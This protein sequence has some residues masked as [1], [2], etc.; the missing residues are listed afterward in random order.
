MSA[1]LGHLASS[2]RQLGGTDFWPEATNFLRACLPFDNV[3]VIA[4]RG[5]G[6]PE[7]LFRQITGPDVFA[8]LDD[9]YLP[10]AYLLDPV[11]HFHL[12]RGA[13]GV[14]RLLDI[15]PDQFA[16]SY[17]YE[18]Y[19]G[20]I[21]IIDEVSVLLPIGSDTTLTIS[22]GTD[23]VSG[24]MFSARAL[25]ELRRH[26]GVILAL[27]DQ[28]WRRESRPNPGAQASASAAATL[29]AGLRTQRGVV[30]S[31]RQA[32]VALLILQGHS[33]ASI[34]LRLG[35]SP[36]TVKVFRR[37]LYARCQV[38]SQAELFAMLIPILERSH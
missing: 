17:Y 7:I 10:A 31:P 22:M 28:H 4:F 11:Y 26:E 3:I 29:I 38:S 9:L 2:L 15:A 30:L 33:S 18:W 25:D 35:L 32:E 24:E 6:A 13:A 1:A 21:G 34:G 8:H 20:R 14:Y 23:S 5:T 36:Q 19:Y 16:R 37:Q 12:R 27:L